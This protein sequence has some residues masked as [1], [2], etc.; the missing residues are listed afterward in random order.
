VHH[1]D[2][3]ARKQGAPAEARAVYRDV[4]YKSIDWSEAL[5]EAWVAFEHLHGSVTDLEDCLDRIERAQATVQARRAK[6]SY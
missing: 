1:T 5:W 2:V 3:S 6:V 4:A